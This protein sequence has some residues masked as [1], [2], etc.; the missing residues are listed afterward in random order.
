M[1][2]SQSFII[3]QYVH[4]NSTIHRLDP[5]AKL[6]IAFLFMMSVMLLK[7]WTSYALSAALVGGIVAISRIPLSYIVRGLKPVWLIVAVTSCFHILLT[8]GGRLLLDA[9]VFSIYEEGV[10]KAGYIAI[11]IILLLV[12]ASLLT[13]TTKLGDLT[14]AIEDLLKPAKRLGLPTQEFALMISWT[15]RFIPI[16]LN[17]TDTVMKAQRARGVR[18]NSGNIFRRLR[19]FIPIIVPVLLLAFQKAESASLA[20]EARGYSPGM[21][22]TQLRSLTFKK[23]DYLVLIISIMCFALLLVITK[24]R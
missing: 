9:G 7:S 22:R 8:Q 14:Q 16:L 20:V 6:V 23:L 21:N 19:S 18:F 13:L 5:R 3:G 10:I 2:L 12:I 15:I 17:E 1:S 4:Q 11:R 24:M